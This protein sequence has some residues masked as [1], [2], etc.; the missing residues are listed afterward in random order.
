MST[1]TNLADTA[2]PAGTVDNGVDVAALE[3]AREALSAAP[4]AARFEWRAT[5]R[6]INGTHSRSTVHSF[7]GLGGEHTHRQA[8]EL[9]GDHP[10]VFASRDAAPTPVET[11]LAGLGSCL[12]AGVASIATKR[13]VQ[14]RSVVASLEGDMDIQ[15]ILGI[16]P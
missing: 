1:T 9:D 3:G 11:V 10:E 16:D 6:W 14:L 4:E 8:F 12:T 7:A 5:T 15:G 13:G 2:G